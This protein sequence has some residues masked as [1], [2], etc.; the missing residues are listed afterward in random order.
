MGDL[1]QRRRLAENEVAVLNGICNNAIAEFEGLSSE[2]EVLFKAMFFLNT[3]TKIHLKLEQ[4]R[5]GELRSTLQQTT[6]QYER[7]EREEA[8]RIEAAQ[9][10]KASRVCNILIVFASNVCIV[11]FFSR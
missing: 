2:I 6:L 5:G 10:E 4:Q 3:T 1:D 9:K 7:E 8:A 11:F